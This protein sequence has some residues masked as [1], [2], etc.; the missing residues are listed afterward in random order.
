MLS[1][2]LISYRHGKVSYLDIRVL[3]EIGAGTAG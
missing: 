2:H 1:S 3:T